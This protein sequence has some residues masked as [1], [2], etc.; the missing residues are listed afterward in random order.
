MSRTAPIP[1][2]LCL[3]VLLALLPAASLRA[4]PPGTSAPAGIAS[5]GRLNLCEAPYFADPTG[6]RD[7]TE[8]ILRALDEVTALTHLSYRRTFQEMKA[9]PAE[10]FHLPPR[11]AENHRENGI[12]RCSPSLDLAYLPVLYLPASTYLVS[13]S[14]APSPP[15]AGVPGRRGSR[16]R[17]CRG[18]R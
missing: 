12:V 11:S 10:G 6:K 1:H 3:L 15:P 14:T 7:S 5:H 4:E 2:G 8:A 13:S 16:L 17:S 9:L 18:P